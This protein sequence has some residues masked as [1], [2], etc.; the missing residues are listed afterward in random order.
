MSE[1]MRFGSCSP[2]PAGPALAGAV[3]IPDGL[4]VGSEHTARY[5]SGDGPAPAG[6]AVQ[7]VAASRP[8]AIAAAYPSL[9]PARMCGRIVTLLG[10]CYSSNGLSVT[11]QDSGGPCPT[12]DIQSG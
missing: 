10:G 6:G 8:K 5:E 11:N 2:G 7:A 1:G 4:A 3:L 9:R 12:A